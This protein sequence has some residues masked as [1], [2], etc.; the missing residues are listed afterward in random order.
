MEL[1]SRVR[2]LRF[3]QLLKE[4]SSEQNPISTNDVIRK[5]KEYWGIDSFRITIG[6]DVAAMRL[7]GIDVRTIKSTSCLYYLAS[8]ETTIPEITLKASTPGDEKEYRISGSVRRQEERTVSKKQTEENLQGSLLTP[9]TLRFICAANGYDAEKIGMYFLDLLP[10]LTKQTDSS[11]LR[12]VNVN[13]SESAERIIE[14]IP[15][16]SMRRALKRD[17]KR[18]TVMQLASIANMIL[19]GA[20]LANAFCDLAASTSDEYEVNLLT[21]AVEDI[22]EI[23]YPDHRAQEVY[24]SRHLEGEYPLFPFLE[25]CNLPILL[26]EGDILRTHIGGKLGYAYVA[27]VPDKLTEKSDFTDESYM[28]YDLGYSDPTDLFAA[29]THIHVCF[30]ERAE[31]VALRGKKLHNLNLIRQEL[32]RLRESDERII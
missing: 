2:L 19:H 27:A 24:E 10:R 30:A 22:I 16:K 28:C 9:D 21:A 17:S 25:R 23:G 5:L 12:R 31:E 1:D 18:F 32:I 4:E 15:S 14:R 11:Y 26:N 29:H 6:R 3:Y 13:L 20:D 8:S 7:A